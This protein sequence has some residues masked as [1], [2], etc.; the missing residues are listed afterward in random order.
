MYVPDQDTRLSAHL[1]IMR[2][3]VI[4]LAMGILTFLVVAIVVRQQDPNQPVPDPP[5]FT[6]TGLGF[7]GL[8]LI[9]QAVIP[10]LVATRLRRQLAAGNWPRLQMS[11]PV[12]MDDVGK[13]CML[14][15]TRL[16]V[17]AALVEGA[18]FFLLIAYLL[19]GQIVALAAAAV[20]LAL[21]LVRFPTQA[22]LESWLSDQQEQLR[23]ERMAG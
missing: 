22:G 18:A 7:A 23:Q 12:P 9:L 5:I 8:Q 13:L 3:L 19:E 15:Q 2:I 14:Y 1:R 11:A 10:G 17:G 4:A 20:M 16:I 6:L 21:V